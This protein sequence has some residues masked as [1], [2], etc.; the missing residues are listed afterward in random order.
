MDNKIEIDDDWDTEY[1]HGISTPTRAAPP[2]APPSRPPAAAPA[3]SH[4]VPCALAS[5]A[6]PATGTSQWDCAAI[7]HKRKSLNFPAFIPRSPMFR[8]SA[9]EGDFLTFTAIPCASGNVEMLGPKLNMRDKQVWEIAIQLAKERAE[10]IGA[11]FEVELR[12]FARRMGQEHPNAL[13]LQSIWRSLERLAAARVKFNIGKGQCKG[14]GSLIATAACIDGKRF[15]RL[16]PDFALPALR[17][18]YQ[19]AFNAPRR[20]TLSTSLARWL[21][22]YFST[23]TKAHP[24]DLRY[25]RTLCGFEAAPRNFPGK[26]VAAMDE[27]VSQAPGVVASYAISKPTKCAD[28]WI[29]TT[30]LGAEKRIFAKPAAMPAEPK[31]SGGVCL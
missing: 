14:I 4:A 30:T 12:E 25:L 16:N 17:C 6:M 28:S 8:A 15:I 26:L 20:A 18:D 27:L 11:R 1:D 31:G 23:H 19:F 2:A 10:G 22:D 5:P 13:A 21:H 3:P 9:A 24:V 29:L 7:P